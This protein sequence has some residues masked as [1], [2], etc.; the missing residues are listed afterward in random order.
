MR[1]AKGV[2]IG[3]LRQLEPLTMLKAL[4]VAGFRDPLAQVGNVRVELPAGRFCS[5]LLM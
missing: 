3:S 2:E 4:S 1:V 5:K